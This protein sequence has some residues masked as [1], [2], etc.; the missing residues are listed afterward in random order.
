VSST[1]GFVDKTLHVNG[2]DNVR[3][4]GTYRDRTVTGTWNASTRTCSNLSCHRSE[5]W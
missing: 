1:N 2:A 5:S 3:F 4:G